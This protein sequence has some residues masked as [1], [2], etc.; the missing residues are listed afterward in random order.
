[1]NPTLDAANAAPR[2]AEPT[3]ANIRELVYAFY[4]RI[5]HRIE[6]HLVSQIDQQARIGNEI[7]EFAAGESIRT[8][9]SYKFDL[10]ELEDLAAAILVWNGLK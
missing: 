8:E 9:Y 3:D 1:M 5:L 2:Y 10:D 7:V 6:M 4:D